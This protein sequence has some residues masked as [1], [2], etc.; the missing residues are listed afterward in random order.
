MLYLEM[1]AVLATGL[2]SGALLTE[3]FVLVPYWKRLAPE[4][5]LR[6]HPSLA[7]SLFRF[8][9]PL[10]IAGTLLPVAACLALIALAGFS[11]WWTLSGL[12]AL[13]ILGFY[14]AFFR[15]ANLQF[16][17]TK[18]ASRAAVTLGVWARLHNLR[19]VIAILGFACAALGFRH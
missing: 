1:M 2:L 6:L 12:C 5:F 16:A 3:A 15:G 9:A 10:T 18:D 4:E 19:T 7:P 13:A 8:F 11:L 14:F 17:Q